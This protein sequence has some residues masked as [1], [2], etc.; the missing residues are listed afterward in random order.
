MNLISV[1]ARKK[2]YKNLDKQ[3][4]C[5][6]IL[7]ILKSGK[8]MTA[9]EIAI[10]LFRRKITTNKERNNAAPRL[11]Y[12]VEAG[13]IEITGKKYDLESGIKVTKYRVIG[14]NK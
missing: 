6:E 10:E 9:R 1:E 8:E 5:A 4:R 14:G 13:L 11:T 2:S 3:K 7:E 12:L